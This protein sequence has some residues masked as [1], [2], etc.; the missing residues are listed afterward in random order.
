MRETFF[1]ALQRAAEERDGVYLLSA[2][3][4]FKLFDSFRASFPT[5]FVDVGIAEA[6]M[7]GIAAGL[8]LS[9]KNV[10]C[11]SMASFL[12]TRAYEQIRVDL[13]YH[14]L[15]VKLIGVG[16]GLSY[17][18]EGYTH[19]GLEDLALMRSVPNMTVVV[20]ADS[21]E[22]AQF[23]TLSLDYPSPLYIRLGQNGQ[24][25]VHTV[26]PKLRIGAPLLLEEGK[27]VALFAT[28]NMVH[29]AREA[30]AMLH[31]H[32][33]STTLVDVH[34]LKPLDVSAVV[35]IAAEH[36]AVFSLEEH[37]LS[38]GLGSSIAEVLVE[39][40]YAGIFRRLGICEPLKREIGDA[41][42]LREAYG[43][44]AAR[45]CETVLQSLRGSCHG[46]RPADIARSC[47][48]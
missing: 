12:V 43:L 20:P 16:G 21:V 35:K 32:G 34:T 22:A 39:N 31:T 19:H 13:A 14:N 36:D 30:V 17:G 41:Q 9:G 44:T 47:T 23:A 33:I 38:G 26:P 37:L 42:V 8:S 24:P 46:H 27:D 3:L 2:D 4:G 40:R 48:K 45:I 6:N 10:Y 1:G 7:V 28:G 15:N 25:R 11:Y 5:K 18:L 29:T